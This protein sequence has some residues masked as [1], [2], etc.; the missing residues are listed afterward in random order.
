MATD[1]AP[2][3]TPSSH[4]TVPELTRTGRPMSVSRGGTAIRTIHTQRHRA[5][6]S[7]KRGV[8]A[9]IEAEWLRKIAE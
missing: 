7:S 9:V 1:A 4:A 8:L 6:Y 2:S 3:A 5:D